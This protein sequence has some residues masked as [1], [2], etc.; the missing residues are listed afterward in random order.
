MYCLLLLLLLTLHSLWNIRPSG[1][2]DETD[3]SAQGEVSYSW[4]QRAAA[5]P[6]RTIF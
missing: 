5:T 2:N 1:L 4:N 6:E 3:R